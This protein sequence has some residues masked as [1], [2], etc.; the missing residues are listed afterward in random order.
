METSGIDPLAP[1]AGIGVV[2][3]ARHAL[4][5]QVGE[6]LAMPGSKPSS[7]MRA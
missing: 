1:A 7:R 3:S 5:E 4:G 2:G 6:R